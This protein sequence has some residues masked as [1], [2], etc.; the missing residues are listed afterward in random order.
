MFV[1]DFQLI[2]QQNYMQF[3]NYGKSNDGLG[4]LSSWMT[5]L[6]MTLKEEGVFYLDILYV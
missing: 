5:N 3:N 6:C 4:G 2:R 1:L